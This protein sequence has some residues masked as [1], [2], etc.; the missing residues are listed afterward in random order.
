[1]NSPITYDQA[2]ELLGIKKS[3]LYALVSQKRVPHI[4]ISGRLVRFCPD[5]LERWMEKHHVASQSRREV[6][7]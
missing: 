3:T 7:R 2:A 6:C 1:M 5:E 4:R